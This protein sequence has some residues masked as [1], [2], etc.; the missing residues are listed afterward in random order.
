MAKKG[1]MAL[2]ACVFALCL[3]LVGCGS[4]EAANKAAF[5][6]TWEASSTTAGTINME[7]QTVNM[8]I[9]DSKLKFEQEGA[10]LT[11]EKGEA[12]EAPKAESSASESAAAEES[13][14]AT[15]SAAAEESA[16]A[17]ESAEAEASESASASASAEAEAS[18]SASSSAAA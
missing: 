16:S 17:S 8:T 9:T 13:A 15:E 18:E 11:F 6:G 14:S 2:M 7:G 10:S 3:A 12:K 1:V 4:N 5:V